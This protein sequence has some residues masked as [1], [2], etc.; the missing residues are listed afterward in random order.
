MTIPF[1]GNLVKFNIASDIRSLLFLYHSLF[2]CFGVFLSSCFCLT[3]HL[4]C[5]CKWKIPFNVIYSKSF[6]NLYCTH[7]HT[8]THTHR[9][10]HRKIQKILPFVNFIQYIHWCVFIDRVAINNTKYQRWM[11]IKIEYLYTH[12]LIEYLH[13][14]ATRTSYTTYRLY[15]YGIATC[16]YIFLFIK[17]LKKEQEKKAHTNRHS[18]IK[19]LVLFF[20]FYFSTCSQ[21]ASHNN[22]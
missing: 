2:L 8:R 13:A 11:N 9:W 1:G 5:L 19:L 14:H 7:I 17:M 6:T 10:M 20:F 4:V 18:S 12:S 3:S 16:M 22:I 15:S 21:F